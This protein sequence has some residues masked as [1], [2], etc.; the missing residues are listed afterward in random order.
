MSIRW[1]DIAFFPDDVLTAEIAASWLWLIGDEDWKPVLCSRLGDLFLERSSGEIDWMSCSLGSIEVAAPN[2]ATFDQLCAEGGDQLAEWFG[3]DFVATLH[4]SGRVAGPN[5][6][7]LFIVLP[8][9]AECTYEA[10]NIGVVPVH[11]VFVGL[12]DIHQQI[13]DLPD[14]QAVRMRVVD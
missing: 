2:R 7:Y 12:A 11:E 6:C 8:I 4:R 13:A 14:G 1:N 9:F 3:P 5:E 10:Q